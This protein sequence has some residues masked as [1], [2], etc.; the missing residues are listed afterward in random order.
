MCHIQLFGNPCTEAHRLPLPIRFPR[1]GY[2]SGLPSSP[3]GDLPNAENVPASTLEFM[4]L[5]V[6]SL[7]L[8]YLGSLLCE[9]PS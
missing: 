7:P 4:H 9:M 5:Q 2:L 1:Q 8:S 3:P 6:D